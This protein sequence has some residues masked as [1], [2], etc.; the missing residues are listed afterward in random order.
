MVHCTVTPRATTV[1][2]VPTPGQPSLAV[3]RGTGSI[4]IRCVSENGVQ[5]QLQ[6]A[7]AL[8]GQ[9]GDWADDGAPQTGTGGV[10]TFTP[11]TSGA[12]KFFRVVVP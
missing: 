3:V 11:A 2:T 12:T 1:V 6:S 8:S 5:Y 7:T 9:P 10:L 4:T